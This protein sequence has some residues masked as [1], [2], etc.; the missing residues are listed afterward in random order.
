MPGRLA[1]DPNWEEQLVEDARLVDGDQITVTT[2]DT[3][4]L[5]DQGGTY[6]RALA[7]G[8]TTSKGQ[9]VTVVFVLD[10]DVCA[11]LI[12]RLYATFGTPEVLRRVERLAELGVTGRRTKRRGRGA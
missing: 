3:G 4:S 7:V 9:P 1:R 2:V 5:L 8:G 12:Y 10:E 11:A 6:R